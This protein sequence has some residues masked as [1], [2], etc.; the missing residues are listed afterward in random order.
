MNI[1][2]QEALAAVDGQI[3]TVPAKIPEGKTLIA[4]QLDR[5]PERSGKFMTSITER[6]LAPGMAVAIKDGHV[7]KSNYVFGR[8]TGGVQKVTACH[9]VTCDKCGERVLMPLAVWEA[10]DAARKQGVTVP[11]TESGM[12]TL[13]RFGAHSCGGK[14]FIDEEAEAAELSR[15]VE[16]A[17]DALSSQTKPV[18]PFLPPRAF[19]VVTLSGTPANLGPEWAW[20]QPP[21]AKVAKMA[22]PF[23]PKKGGDILLFNPGY[24][25]GWVDNP[26]DTGLF[27]VENGVSRRQPV[28][29][30]NP[31]AVEGL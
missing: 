5:D 17:L 24:W 9:Y 16:R 27:W 2:M 30:F 31:A 6:W 26:D 3:K 4:I 22:V 21:L 25:L 1:M 13:R 14:W 19:S 23:E 15:F 28:A 11:P 8:V 7:V 18:P 20:V 29:K 12:A 10:K